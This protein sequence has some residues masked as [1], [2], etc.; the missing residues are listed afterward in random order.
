M[1]VKLIST[2]SLSAS[3]DGPGNLVMRGVAAR[4]C[5]AQAGEMFLGEMF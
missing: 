4:L 1:E 5:S 3:E 2:D